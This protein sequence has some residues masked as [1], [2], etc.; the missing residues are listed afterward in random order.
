MANITNLAFEQIASP[1]LALVPRF[2][3]GLVGRIFHIELL[4]VERN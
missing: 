4:A 1:Q 2:V 3:V